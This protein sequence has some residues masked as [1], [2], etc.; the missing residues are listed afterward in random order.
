[1]AAHSSTGVSLPL[2]ERIG[3]R[4]VFGL[5]W[6][7]MISR[8]S[9]TLMMVVDTLFVSRLGTAALAGVGI[10]I[11]GSH[12]VVGFG[13][14]LLMGVRVAVSHYTGAGRPESAARIGWQGAWLAALLGAIAWLA[15]P[16]AAW[17]LS[18]TGAEGEVLPH[19]L[20]FLQVRVAGAPL[21]FGVLAVSGYFQGTGDT[22]TPMVGTLLANALNLALNPLFIFG[23]GPVPALGA[24]GAA[25]ATV[26]SM[27]V[28]LAWLGLRFLRHTPRVARGPQ[29]A[30]LAEITRPGV[31]MGMNMLQE[32]GSF[33]IFM[34]FLAHC[35]AIHLAAH[36]VVVRI[37]LMSFL[38]GW[39]VGEAGGVLVGQ[40]LGGR[41]PELARQAWRASVT[42]ALSFM[43]A[44]GVLFVAF[45]ATLLSI[46]SPAPE[47]LELGVRMLWIAAAFQIF[48]AVATVGLCCLNGAGDNRFTM[49]LQLIGA[50]LLKVP[51]AWLFALP[52]GLGAPGA[53]LGMTLD[54]V[55]LA[56]LCLWRIRGDRWLSAA[57]EPERRLSEAL[58]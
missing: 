54:I 37:V 27:G 43:G 36:V 46:F 38:P 57:P 1:M 12:L 31:P 11:S 51:L 29:R 18:L 45:P 35:G 20:G 55:M 16:F 2:P 42:L 4:S 7:M 26:I 5:A 23:W 13:W 50:W 28:N 17:G 19:A 9:D 25:L 49:A 52:L 44:F 8:M 33:A 32:I 24:A 3:W 21:L 41:R 48:D 47:V 56:A 14:G 53:W 6:P 40:A 58:A 10:A 39:A 30:L 15:I 22:R 34:A